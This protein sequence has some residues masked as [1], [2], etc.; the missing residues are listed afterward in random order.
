MKLIFLGPQGCGKGTQAE[1]ISKKLWI[2]HVSTGDLLRHT[3]GETKKIMES[4]SLKGQLVPVKIVVGV[5]KEKLKS[6][7]CKKGFILDG[8]PRDMEQAKELAKFVKIDK[9]IDIFISDKESITRL[10]SRLNCSK[11]G[12]VFNTL[13]SPPKK[14]GICD[15]CSSALYVRE[16]DKPAAI[17]KRLEIYHKQTEPLLKHYNAHKV[18]GGQEINKVTEDILNAIKD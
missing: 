18:D 7:D 3:F 1:I 16:D 14:Q 12:A 13:T 4:Y 6:N 5:I 2:C 15:E 10:S 17:K 9:A 8:F 11:C